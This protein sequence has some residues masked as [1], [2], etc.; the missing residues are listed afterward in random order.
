MKLPKVILQKSQKLLASCMGSVYTTHKRHYPADTKI[1]VITHR[2]NLM[3]I[4]I[5][6]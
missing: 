5:E 3:N 1:N 4:A 6:S 2:W